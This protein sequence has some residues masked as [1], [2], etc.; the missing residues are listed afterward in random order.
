MQFVSP[1]CR[2]EWL[3]ALILLIAALPQL[4]RGS[5]IFSTGFEQ[6]E[7]YNMGFTLVG[8]QGWVGVGTGGTDVFSQ[9]NNQLGLIG[10]WAPTSDSET[11][12]SVWRPINL[13]TIPSNGIVRFAVD[14][15]IIDSSNGSYDDFRWSAYNA[16][17]NRLFSLV[18]DNDF[19]A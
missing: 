8:Q 10:N 2:R 5:T 12:T 1:L 13:T 14:M 15:T 4:C 17:S 6:S 11:F 19:L 3:L 9:N 16:S 7:G 18:F